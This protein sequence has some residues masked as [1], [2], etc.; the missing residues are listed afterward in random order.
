MDTFETCAQIGRLPKRA[1]R[2]ARV[3]MESQG[4]FALPHDL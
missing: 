4:L 3:G 2:N 1:M